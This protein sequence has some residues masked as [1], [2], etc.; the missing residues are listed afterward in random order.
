[1]TRLYD[2]IGKHYASARTTDPDIEKSLGMFLNTA[3]SVLNVG[4]GTGS[5][6]QNLTGLVAL[7]P[8]IEMIQQRSPD[9]AP[10][11][12]ASAQYL[13]FADSAFSHVLTILSM[14]HWQQ[15]PFCFA[16]VKRVTSKAFVALTWNPEAAP[17]WLT[18]DYFHEIHEIDQAIFPTKSELENAFPGIEFHSLPVPSHCID[19]FTAAYWSRP[20]AYLDENIR[21]SM[22]T[23]GKI[24]KLEEGLGQLKKDLESGSWL[25]K[26]SSLLKA[27]SLDVGYVIAY[28][29]KN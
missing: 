14:H 12:Q 10:V 2:K 25:E 17:W 6:E 9:A 29:K 8:S 26:N 24:K 16:E 7:E 23:F 27:D 3:S 13:P 28:W 18:R 1:M 19:G 22:S 5:Y 21:R 11:V 15:R 20:E 4:A